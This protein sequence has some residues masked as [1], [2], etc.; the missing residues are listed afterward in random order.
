[1]R[2]AAKEW[3]LIGFTLLSQSAVGAFWAL[4]AA[5]A[6]FSSERWIFLAERAIFVILVLGGTGTLLSLFHLGR[7]LRAPNALA[8]LRD[9]WL[10][11]E[12]LSDLVFLGTAAAL[13]VLAMLGR[14]GGALRTILIIFG[15]TAGFFLIFTMSRIYM[16]RTVPVWK[17]PHTPVSFFL[18][19]AFLGPLLAAVLSPSTDAIGFAVR[20]TF[21]AV[22]LAVAGLNLM[23]MA[24]LTPSVGFLAKPPATLLAFPESRIRA[25]LAVRSIFLL[26]SA[27]CLLVF[28][29]RS[30]DGSPAPLSFI[31]GAITALASE[32]T[33]RALF[34]A[35]YS[36]VGV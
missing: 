4:A 11:R 13:W 7:P 28:L 16:L 2:G 15:A 6:A 8:N 9:S 14:N 27:A 18:S 20:W 26:A 24:L 29:L 34:Y 30:A 12:I 36:R 31:A 22:A 25:F 17:G 10:S 32:I 3:P 21:A 1:M 19:A 5:E 35:M 33:G 23:S